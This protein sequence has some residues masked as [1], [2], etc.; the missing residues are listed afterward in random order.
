[1]TSPKPLSGVIYSAGTS[2]VFSGQANASLGYAATGGTAVTI[3][4]VGYKIDSNQWLQAIISSAYKVTWSLAASMT[5][6]L[7]TARFNATD[8]K[9]NTVVST[10]YTVL[11]D[12]SAPTITFTTAPGANLNANSPVVASIV[13]TLGDLNS[14]SVTA[15]K[16]GTAIASTSIT[17]TGT[18]NPGGSVTYTVNINGLGSGT[19][20]VTLNAKDLAGNTATAVTLKVHV[21]VPFNQSFTAPTTGPGAAQQCTQQGSTGACVTWTNNLPS[22]QTVSVWFV[23]YNAKNQVVALGFQGATLAPGVSSAS[24]SS[25]SLP[26]GSYTV[27]TFIVSSAGSGYSQSLPISV[28]L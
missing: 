15:T 17:T 27:Q 25:Q 12:T 18:N 5:S 28:T 2:V 11:V 20:S 26:S 3:S 6:G 10:A 22:A 14:T 9:S 7:H 4:S 19:W 16:N 13:D 1:V 21:T 23:W 24:F 8:S